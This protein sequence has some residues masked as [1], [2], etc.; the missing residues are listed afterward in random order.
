M[1]S[2]NYT[3]SDHTE[4]INSARSSVV[5]VVNEDTYYSG[6]IFA[7]ENDVV[8]ILTTTKATKNSSP[9]VVFDNDISVQSAIVG[10]DTDSGVAL[11]QVSV[12]FDVKVFSTLDTLALMPG[13]NVVAMS[14]KNLHTG[15]ATYSGGM[16]SEPGSWRTISNTR[17]L[18]SMIEMDVTTTTSQEGGALI[19]LNGTLIGMVVPQPV[20]SNSRMSYALSINELKLI[21]TSLKNNGTVTRGSFDVMMKD[22]SGM[23]AYEKSAYNISIDTRNGVFVQSL[24]ADQSGEDNLMVGDIITAID[25]VEVSSMSDLMGILYT[26]QPNDTVQVTVVRGGQSR[27]VSVVLE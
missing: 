27:M 26:H 14:G 4:A 11:L 24:L 10:E 5:S 19:D 18:S 25:G 7:K 15:S 3:T 9:T 8:Y 2:T 16:I 13:A 12:A 6:V 21:Y 20:Q 1:D 22:V 23:L 17:W